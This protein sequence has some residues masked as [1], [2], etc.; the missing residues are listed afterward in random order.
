M[1]SGDLRPQKVP[2]ACD[3]AETANHLILAI[4]KSF[5]PDTY[6]FLNV[7]AGSAFAALNDS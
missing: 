2:E 4:L 5:N 7:L 3:V 1:I 6:S